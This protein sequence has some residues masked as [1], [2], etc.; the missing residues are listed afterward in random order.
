MLKLLFLLRMRLSKEDKKINDCLNEIILFMYNEIES[1]PSRTLISFDF[2][3]SETIK[4]WSKHQD[5]VKSDG[6]DLTN[7]IK[8]SNGKYSQDIISQSITAFI[9]I[10]INSF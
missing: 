4:Y 7:F 10:L 9:F 3:P 5:E 2:N 1:S 8:F 6:E